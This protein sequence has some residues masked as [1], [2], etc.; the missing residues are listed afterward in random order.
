VSR[1]PGRI[2][3]AI[4]ALFDTAPD[5]AFTTDELASHCYDLDPRQIERK[6]W[7]AVAR[8]AKK[9]LECDPG[10]RMAWAYESRNVYYNVASPRSTALVYALRFEKVLPGPRDATTHTTELKALPAAQW[11]TTH[12]VELAALAR[13]LLTENDPDAIRAGLTEIAEALERMGNGD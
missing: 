5:W 4:R 2:E 7:V 1:G 9:V 10:W 13:R 3:R 11:W 12:T 6:H 8:A